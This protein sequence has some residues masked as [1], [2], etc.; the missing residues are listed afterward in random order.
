MHP[1]RATIVGIAASLAAVAVS[2][3]HDLTY[4]QRVAC[5]R[6]IEAVYWENRAWPSGRSQPK[7]HLD[8]VMPQV[9]RSRKV[10]AK[11]DQG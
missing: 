8:E 7:P 4:D 5:Q 10:L 3:P 2:Y 9:G 6:S 11:T 1:F